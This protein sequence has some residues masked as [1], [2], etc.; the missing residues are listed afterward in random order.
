VGA[1]RDAQCL[2]P[3]RRPA[4]LPRPV[5]HGLRPPRPRARREVG[6]G[7]RP[8]P[9]PPP[10]RKRR[11]H[12]LQVG[13]PLRAHVER[14]APSRRRDAHG[15]ALDDRHRLATRAGPGLGAR[16]PP[17]AGG[18]LP[19][20]SRRLRGAL[21][22]R[23]PDRQRDRPHRP[24][25]VPPGHVRRGAAHRRPRRL[26]PLQHA[27][28][29]SRRPLAARRARLL[30][31]EGLSGRSSGGRAVRGP[32]TCRTRSRRPLRAHLRRPGA[33]VA[34][35]AGSPPPGGAVRLPASRRQR[36]PGG[37]PGRRGGHG[38]AGPL[39]PPLR[40]RRRPRP[41]P[42][43][44]LGRLAPGTAAAV[45]GC[46]RT[47]R[48]GAVGPVPPPASTPPPMPHPRAW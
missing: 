46:R 33:A 34:A 18:R 3:G 30:A 8:L 28:R 19:L 38:R 10:R 16:H 13:K 32:R 41:R 36:R 24:V 25:R 31:R 5:R 43:A 45:C 4:A 40:L 22:D 15:G 35:L 27:R 1:G 12:D 37:G 42:H 20:R 14:E 23:R 29:G 26:D 7:A 48:R 17:G 11:L 2:V 39:Q 6:G 44:A 47:G 9:R 21:P